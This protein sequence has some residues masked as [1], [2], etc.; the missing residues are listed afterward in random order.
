MVDARTPDPPFTGRFTLTVDG[1]EIGAFTEVSGLAV[2][3]D[4]EEVVEGGQNQ[5]TH[6]LPKGMKW[7]NIV[8]KRGLTN[9]NEL[10]GWLSRTSGEGFEAAGHRLQPRNATIKVLDAKGKVVRSWTLEGAVPVKWTGPRLAASS[11][12]L[13][14]EELEVSHR[15]FVA[16]S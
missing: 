15:G 6:R 10:F 13:A 12:D 14:N 5:F 16:S 9:S 7:Q 2:T 3:I 1:V 11:R 8:L 4:V